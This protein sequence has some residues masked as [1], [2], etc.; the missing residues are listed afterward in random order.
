MIC[1]SL[2]KTQNFCLK[3]DLVGK[4]LVTKDNCC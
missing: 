1:G 4:G 3:T 2:A